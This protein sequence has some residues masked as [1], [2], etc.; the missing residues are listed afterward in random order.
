MQDILHLNILF[1]YII[2]NERLI[3]NDN[4]KVFIKQH[5]TVPEWFVNEYIDMVPMH[6]L[7]TDA[8]VDLD[9]VARQ[10]NSAKR[11]LFAT[12][13]IG[14]KKN[15]DYIIVTEK[16][17]RSGKY[18]GN[19]Y[20]KILLTPDCFKRLCMLSRAKNAEFVRSYYFAIEGLLFK[21]HQQMLEGMKH[22]IETLEKAR[23]TTKSPEMKMGYIYVIRAS[24]KK[25][26]VYKIG[27]SQN[28]L[29]R[30]R[31][32]QSG[33]LEDIEVVFKW[34]TDDLK[35]MENCVKSFL[36]KERH[37]KYKEIYKA[38]LEM[39]KMIIH[40]CDEIQ[41]AKREYTMR[42]ASNMNGGYYVVIMNS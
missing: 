2:M 34:R 31:T 42:S 35:S 7:Q 22:E 11:T 38:N 20:K 41:Q 12:L 23:A 36:D 33:K 21:Y 28:L 3:Q 14:Y 16:L 40:K 15:I 30:L 18:G 24:G 1:Y 19:N 37:M 6:S 8:V 29:A 39:I 13:R 10:L 32:Y 26:S 25:D 4:V 5:T 9:I 17:T 27:R